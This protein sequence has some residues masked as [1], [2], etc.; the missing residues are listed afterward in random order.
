MLVM[1]HL[2]LIYHWAM[3][4]RNFMSCLM[5]I[6]IP[7]MRNK[8]MPSNWA[9]LVSKSSESSKT[10]DTPVSKYLF[11]QNF[12]DSSDPDSG[13]PPTIANQSHQSEDEN[14]VSAKNYAH[15]VPP[16]G[17]LPSEGAIPTEGAQPSEGVLQ[18]G[19]NARFSVCEGD[20]A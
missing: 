7:A 16:E 17:A 11:N 4:L 10:V 18:P 5:T 1:W 12:T 3:Y 15:A 14:H 9:N 8:T 19:S 2:Y 20:E 6:L 13:L